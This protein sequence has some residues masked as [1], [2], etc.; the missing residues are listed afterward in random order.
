MPSDN[1]TG[2]LIKIFADHSDTYT[3]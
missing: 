2:T 1:T 3:F